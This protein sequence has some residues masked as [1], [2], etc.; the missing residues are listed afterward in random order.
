MKES[1][2]LDL[3]LSNKTSPKNL[4]IDKYTQVREISRVGQSRMERLP[5]QGN[6]LR[7]QAI[8]AF[9]CRWQGWWECG[10][11][12]RGVR[13]RQIAIA[14][15][16]VNPLQFPGQEPIYVALGWLVG[17]V[18]VIWLKKVVLFLCWWACVAVLFPFTTSPCVSCEVVMYRRYNEG[19]KLVEVNRARE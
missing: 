6:H 10:P 14:R 5:N 8:M 19:L 7:W 2:G 17:W 9:I 4:V 15:S 16:I 18:E 1:V 13:A 3:P 12:G 11:W